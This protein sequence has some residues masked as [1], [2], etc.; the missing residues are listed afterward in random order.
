MKKIYSIT[1]GRRTGSRQEHPKRPCAT[2]ISKGKYK[3]CH[4]GR[5]MTRASGYFDIRTTA[6]GLVN[7]NYKYCRLLQKNNG[8]LYSYTGGNSSR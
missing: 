6:G 7:T 3:D 5:A 1:P 8:Y 2:D 4:I